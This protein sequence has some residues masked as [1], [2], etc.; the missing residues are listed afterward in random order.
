MTPARKT[1][2][3]RALGNI[4]VSWAN[5]FLSTFYEEYCR[6]HPGADLPCFPLSTQTN[7]KY[8]ICQVT[9]CD[10]LLAYAPDSGSVAQHMLH[11]IFGPKSITNMENL[12]T[13][14]IPDYFKGLCLK[15]EFPAKFEDYCRGWLD[16]F[17]LPCGLLPSPTKKNP[18]TDLTRN[19]S[20][21]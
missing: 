3:Q 1:I 19:P 10:A 14:G 16:G 20:E 12:Q 8:K 4:L 5:T 13:C 9:L 18:S 11:H 17:L 2:P 15:P 21:Q 7:L 6:K